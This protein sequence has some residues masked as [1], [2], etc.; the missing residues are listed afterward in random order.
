MTNILETK[1]IIGGVAY[2]IPPLHWHWHRKVVG[3]FKTA[4]ELLDKMALSGAKLEEEA[5]PAATQAALEGLVDMV[6]LVD[7]GLKLAYAG[8]EQKFHYDTIEAHQN[9]KEPPI[10]PKLEDLERA[11]TLEESLGIIQSTALMLAAMTPKGT[12]E[13]EAPAAAESAENGT[14]N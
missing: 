6:P 1:F 2:A 9:G 8:I 13:G 10:M 11:L 5:G 12:A 3:E 7:A 14:A 4:T